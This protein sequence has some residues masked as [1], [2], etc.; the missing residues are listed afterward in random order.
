MTPDCWVNGEPGIRISTFDRGL[1][2]G[3]GLFETLAV[4][5]GRIRLLDHHLQ[6]LTMGCLRLRL[7]PLPLDVVKDE[8]THA[9]NGQPQAVLKLIVT[10]GSGG[11]GYRPSASTQTTRILTRHPCP[12]HPAEYI[13]YGIRMRVC[14]TR[15]SRNR[16]LAGLKHLNRLEQV[17]ARA[18]WTEAD[19]IQE[20]L[21]MDEEGSVIEGIMTNVFV[22]LSHGVLATPSLRLAGVAGVMRRHILECAQQTGIPI[23]IAS[24]SLTEIMQAAEIF[25]CNSV[26]GVWP[27]SAID[28]WKFTVGPMTRRAQTW[29]TQ[30]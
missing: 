17:L 28:H 30:C 22:R 25:V 8:L 13:Q 24:L 21:M 16:A 15:L 14:N 20:G 19:N 5:L 3:D 29:A 2:Y 7:P 23:R 26:I 10:R 11:C 6:R 27:V 4:R 12:E 9:A 1:H 18:E